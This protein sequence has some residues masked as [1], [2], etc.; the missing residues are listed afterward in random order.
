MD[1]NFGIQ[2]INRNIFRQNDNIHQQNFGNV[3]YRNY[4]NYGNHLKNDLM[5]IND[6]HINNQQKNLMQNENY[7]PQ[8][9]RNK[10]HEKFQT[11][12]YIQEKQTQ[13]RPT[14]N[15]M[16]QRFNMNMN[17]N[18]NQ[19]NPNFYHNK[20][21]FDIRPKNDFSNNNINN[22]N[23]FNNNQIKIETQLE[24]PNPTTSPVSEINKKLLKA[25]IYIYYFEKSLAD[26]NE[27]NLF[28]N[29]D[30]DFYLINPDFLKQFKNNYPYNAIKKW[31]DLK[32]N[33][34]NYGDIKY[35]SSLIELYIDELL[36]ENLLKKEVVWDGLKNIK[37]I[38]TTVTKTCGIIHTNEGM[39]LPSKIMDIIKSFDEKVKNAVKPKNFIFLSNSVY[40]INNPNKIIIGNLERSNAMFTPEYI[41]EY[42]KNIEKSE[43]DKLFHNYIY[44]YI[45]ILYN[46]YYYKIK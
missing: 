22:N 31:L 2:N 12:N 39:I 20:D 7:N 42:N 14:E 46:K 34:Y 44:S 40:Y 28:Y 15:Y 38:Y 13:I 10:T 24:T 43:I 35:L 41:F 33:S 26:K 27:K 9:R 17:D 16:K 18:R 6:F 29:S 19:H 21:K 23:K 4:G 32:R 1:Y 45:N 36:K 25:L 3:N 37:V 5:N 8:I 11:N 30:T